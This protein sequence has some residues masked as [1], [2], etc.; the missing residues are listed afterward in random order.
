MTTTT[1]T[2]IDKLNLTQEE[3]QI[4]ESLKKEYSS[5][6]TNLLGV[7]VVQQ[8]KE[9]KYDESCEEIMELEDEIGLSKLEINDNIIEA[10]KKEFIVYDKNLTKD[11]IPILII[12]PSILVELELSE[13][14]QR[15]AIFH[16]IYRILIT[17]PEAT[18]NGLFIILDVN[19]LGTIDSGKYG[20]KIYNYLKKLPARPQK[21]IFYKLSWLLSWAYYFF[22]KAL[23]TR[24]QERVELYDTK[25]SLVDNVGK[26]NLIP[27]YGGEAEYNINQTI[28]DIF[29][30]KGCQIV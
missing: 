23:P 14:D 11:G 18:T 3:Y 16:T 25:E 27:S 29:C 22:K 13:E 5:I 28:Q 21:I 10:L 15:V 17:D 2:F 6:S 19:D 26:E 1:T 7:I 12:R 9:K 24:M 8:R 30:K 4:F 20:L